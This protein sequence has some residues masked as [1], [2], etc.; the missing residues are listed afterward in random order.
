MQQIFVQIVSL[1]CRKNIGK[2]STPVFPV[3]LIR[4]MALAGD[5]LKKMGWTDPPITTFR[6]NNMLTGSH[7]P[8]EKTQEV[9]G[10]LPYSLEEGVNKTLCWMY[11][12]GLIR[13]KTISFP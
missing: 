5:L 10:D 13:N 2:G 4:L 9:V 11:E 3:V 1:C 6:L 8:I 7:Y 12:Q